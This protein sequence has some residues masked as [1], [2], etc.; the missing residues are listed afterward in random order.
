MRT[1]AFVIEPPTVS[2]SGLPGYAAVGDTPEAFA[3]FIRDDQTKWG[4]LMR[5]AGIRPEGG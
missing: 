4:R 5:E 1:L 2:E 3:K